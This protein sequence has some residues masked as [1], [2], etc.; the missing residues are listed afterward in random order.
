MTAIEIREIRVADASAYIEL[1]QRLDRESTFLLWE[2]GERTITV[3]ALRAHMETVDRTQ[4]LH[5]LAT[6][7]DELVGFL[8]CIRG[9]VRR[10]RHRCDFTMA[11]L[12][13]HQR[14]GVGAGLLQATEVWARA[15]GIRRIELTVMSHNLAAIALY[16]RAGFVLEG[17]K[18]GA[19]QVDDA[20]VDECVMGKT[21]DG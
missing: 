9:A 7:D 19:I 11:V 17:V 3:E 10:L 12:S 15:N 14:N 16:E 21:L 18:R 4:R 20:P 8:V 13:G 5:L 1:L 6:C 2:P